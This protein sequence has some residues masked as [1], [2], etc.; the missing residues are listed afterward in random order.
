M[1]TTPTSTEA[2]VSQVEGRALLDVSLMRSKAAD[3]RLTAGDIETPL[4][5][6]Y[7]RRAAELELEA[8]ALAARF[9]LIEQLEL[10]A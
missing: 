10:A 6:T 7:L 9:G 2:R 1:H 8:A 3:L 4:S 5:T